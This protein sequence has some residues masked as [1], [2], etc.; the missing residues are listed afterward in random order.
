MKRQFLR[1]TALMGFLAVIS[2]APAFAQSVPQANLTVPF[3]FIVG[4]RTLPAGEYTIRRVRSDEDQ[5]FLVQSKDARESSIV[6]TSP[7]GSY[8]ASFES[9]VVFHKYG[10]QY[11]LS[12]IWTPGESRGREL[13][14]SGRERSLR[15][16]M[17]KAPSVSPAMAD[18]TETETVT[19]IGH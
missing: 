14:I 19:L 10:N 9:K 17:A 11:V 3:D 1:A 5:L 18:T 8:T 16:E 12:Q 15:R 2:A 7:V 4:K 13:P 6:I